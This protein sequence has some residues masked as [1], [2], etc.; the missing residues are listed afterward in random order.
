MDGPLTGAEVEDVRKDLPGLTALCIKRLRAFGLKGLDVPVDECF[1]MTRPQRWS[2]LWRAAFEG[3]RFCED[4]P[5]KSATECS[6][7]S[8]GSRIWFDPNRPYETDGRLYRVEFI[9]RRT[10]R[11]GNFGHMGG[12]EHEMVVDRMISIKEVEAP[13]PR[14]TDEEER[15]AWEACEAS[16]QCISWEKMKEMQRLR[17]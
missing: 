13:P 4:Q 14:V 17:K 9:G 11:P 8:V 3:S 2:G 6:D 15:V 7:K 12:S 1:E 10:V 16:G 5:N